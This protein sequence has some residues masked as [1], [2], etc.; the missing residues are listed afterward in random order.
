MRS[1]LFSL[2]LLL[3]A[4]ALCPHAQAQSAAPRDIGKTDA[5]RKPL[6]DALRGPVEKDLGQPVQFVVTT[7]RVQDGW[8]FV[9]ATPQTKT[10]QPIDYAATR[11]AQAMADGVFDGGTIFALLKSDSDKADKWSVTEFVIGPTDV[12]YLA[13]PDQHGAPATLF[14]APAG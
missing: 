7:L 9:I 11:Y 14:E 2:S 6:L 1:L 12:A 4:P 3:A 5:Q 13:W 10:G 8:A